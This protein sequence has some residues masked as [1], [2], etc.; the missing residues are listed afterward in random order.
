VEARGKASKSTKDFREEPGSE[1]ERKGPENKAQSHEAILIAQK[2]PAFSH[3]LGGRKT[4]RAKK[5]EHSGEE[6]V[7]R[8]GYSKK[9]TGKVSGSNGD[10]CGRSSNKKLLIQS[11]MGKR[12]VRS[13]KGYCAGGKRKEFTKKKSGDG[14]M[15]DF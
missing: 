14:K 7:S 13:T 6:G 3:R 5:Q 8:F 11:E 10:S 2:N 15:H 1:K 4:C 9:G 12:K